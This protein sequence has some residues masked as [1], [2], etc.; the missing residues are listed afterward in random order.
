MTVRPFYHN[1]QS[2]EFSHFS[3]AGQPTAHL[4]TTTMKSFITPLSLIS[5]GLATLGSAATIPTKSLTRR[6]TETC[7]QWGTIETGSY[8]VYNDLWGQSYDESGTQCTTVDS[9]SGSTI[10]WSTTWSW[11]GA[12]SQVKSFADVS[13]QFTAKTLKSISSITSSWKWR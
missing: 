2:L 9:L 10:A 11:S 8:I 5:L 6:S 4:Q 13:L 12:S 7:D 3:T 1:Q